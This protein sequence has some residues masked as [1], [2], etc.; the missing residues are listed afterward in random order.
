MRHPERYGPRPADPT[1]GEYGQ[2]QSRARGITRAILDTFPVIRYSR[3][4][5]DQPGSGFARGGASSKPLDAES[6]ISDS[7]D[8]SIEMGSLSTPAAINAAAL[9]GGAAA[10]GAAARTDE[11]RR[12]GNTRSSSDDSHVPSSPGAGPSRLSQDRSDAHNTNGQQISEVPAEGGLTTLAAPIP[13]ARNTNA[14]AD[15]TNI[16]PDSIGRE[17]CPICIVDFEEGDDLRVLPCEGK[18]VFHQECVDQWLLE[19]SSSCPICRH[20]KRPT[21][22]FYFFAMTRR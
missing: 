16:I 6:G 20:G 10:T 9:G 19:L 3:S 1:M 7:F 12:S 15:N 2:G 21:S 17:T 4:P 8:H 14:N 18:H 11:P 5:M 22:S 13:R